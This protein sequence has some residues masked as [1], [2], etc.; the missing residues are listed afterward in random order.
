MRFP[1]LK[2]FQNFSKQLIHTNGTDRY[3]TLR[4]VSYII[5]GGCAFGLGTL[6]FFVYD[7]VYQTIDR[8]QAIIALRSDIETQAVDFDRLKRLTDAWNA[9]H[10]TTTLTIAR[11]PF[12]PF[13]TS[14]KTKR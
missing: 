9:K 3:G 4:I 1:L 13:T 14:T 7:R 2:Q 6:G 10:A 5:F 8:M 11:D 12:S